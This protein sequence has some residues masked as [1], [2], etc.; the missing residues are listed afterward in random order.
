VVLPPVGYGAITVVADEGA[1][2]ISTEEYAGIEPEAATGIDEAAG[3]AVD[4]ATGT[5]DVQSDGRVTPWFLAQ[6]AGSK[7]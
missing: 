1:T 3:G 2:V 6:V 5:M 7:P 4:G